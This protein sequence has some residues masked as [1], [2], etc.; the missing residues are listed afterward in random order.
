MKTLSKILA[1]L[2]LSSLFIN[3][4]AQDSGS[5]KHEGKNSAVKY[6]KM[7]IRSAPKFTLQMS[8]SYD[9]G[10]YELSSNNNGD[11]SSEEFVKGENFG[12]RHGFSGAAT[13]K[14]ALHQ[15]GNVRLNV[16]AIYSG[17]SSK[18]T[19]LN[20]SMTEPDFVNYSIYSGVIALENNFTPNY[21]FKTLIGAGLIGSII[22]GQARVT[23]EGNTQNLDIIPAFRL[24]VTAFSGLEYSL[25]N[26]LGVN[27]GFK[28]THAN[29]WLK[30][31]KVSNDPTKIY[32]NDKRVLPRI[33][34]SGFRQFAWG[35]FY[36]GINV[37][38]GVKE[39]QYIIKQY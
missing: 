39:K 31:T 12:V 19:K 7:T 23:T 37:Y 35:S 18:Y 28:F 6:M 22:S 3:L 17:F 5:R 8:G 10:V 15:R 33:P 4:Y 11:F 24:G 13:L 14:I 9:Y 16:S 25:S 38:F 26:Q 1:I 32:L 30:Q 2:L 29:L 34:Y 21:R 27:L 36:A 20:T